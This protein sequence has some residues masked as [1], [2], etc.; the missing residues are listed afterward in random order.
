M[1]FFF[2]TFFKY[3]DKHCG[4]NFL[5][6]HAQWGEM[7]KNVL[8]SPKSFKLSQF[9]LKMLKRA[10]NPFKPL[11][12]MK[13]VRNER[14]LKKFQKATFKPLFH[15]EKQNHVKI[16]E[17]FET[18]WNILENILKSFGIFWTFCSRFNPL[19]CAQC[20]D[21]NKSL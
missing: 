2:K 18:F 10:P 4:L 15:S 12:L 8:K 21:D 6:G 14:F 16:V 17:Q 11:L 9:G 20:C 3:V 1:A 19:H 7:G 13:I 5:H